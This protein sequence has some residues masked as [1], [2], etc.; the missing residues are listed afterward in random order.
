MPSLSSILV[1]PAFL[2]A[3][4]T[5]NLVCLLSSNLYITTDFKI[6]LAFKVH[7][8]LLDSYAEVICCPAPSSTFPS[9]QNT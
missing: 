9:A 5:G 4:Y 3:I 2:R 1:G 6:A 7:I 8:S